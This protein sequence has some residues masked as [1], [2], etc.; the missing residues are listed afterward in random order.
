[1][2]EP[3]TA[4]YIYYACK[5]IYYVCALLFFKTMTNSPRYC[6]YT[7][8]IITYGDNKRGFHCAPFLSFSLFPFSVYHFFSSLYSSASS[9]PN[10]PEYLFFFCS[11]TNLEP[12]L[13]SGLLVHHLYRYATRSVEESPLKIKLYFIVSCF[14]Q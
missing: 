11:T 7:S 12:S 10:F 8:L 5:H 14:D 13:T 4:P 2:E 3:R 6:I 1:M 9:C